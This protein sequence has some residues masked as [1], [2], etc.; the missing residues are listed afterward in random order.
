MNAHALLDDLMDVGIRLKRDGDD[1]IADVL[2][3]AD[4]SAHSQRI[5]A[6]KLALAC[7]L[8]LREQIVAAAT[9]SPEHFNRK[10]YDALW[11]LWHANESKEEPT[12]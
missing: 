1:L 6:S 11:A 2:P 5:K 7:A 12:P 9:V 4:L 10:E 8:H 3:T